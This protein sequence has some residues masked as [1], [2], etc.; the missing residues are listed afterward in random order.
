[1]C[2]SSASLGRLVGQ[3][4]RLPYSSSV[5]CRRRP[6][7]PQVP[8]RRLSKWMDKQAKPQS[9]CSCPVLPALLRSPGTFQRDSSLDP[10]AN[11]VHCCPSTHTP[12]VPSPAPQ[13]HPR[14]PVLTPD[15]HSLWTLNLLSCL[16]LPAHTV[17]SPKNSIPFP[18]PGASWRTPTHCT[19]P[20]APCR[21]GPASSGRPSRPS[22]SAW[23]CHCPRCPG[24]TWRGGCAIRAQTLN[25]WERERRKR[26]RNA[27]VVPSE[28]ALPIRRA[29][30]ALRNPHPGREGKW[31]GTLSIPSVDRTLSAGDGRAVPWWP[32]PPVQSAVG[33]KWPP[34]LLPPVSSEIRPEQSDVPLR[35]ENRI[36]AW[37]E[38]GAPWAGRDSCSHQPQPSGPDKIFTAC[39]PGCVSSWVG[40]AACVVHGWGSSR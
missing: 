37:E 1:M 24:I 7:T 22:L 14:C 38:A 33:V 12:Q 3:R 32:L 27:A 13:P 19:A 10:G 36:P 26:E 23:L 40:W 9:P 31:I 28:D 35:K 20:T 2:V 6:S 39:C 15:S 5:C 34:T 18:S 4:L 17:S 30:T 21:A 8:E 25:E 16:C 11:V 29:E